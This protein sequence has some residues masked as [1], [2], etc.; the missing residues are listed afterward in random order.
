MPGGDHTDKNRNS[1]IM[2]LEIIRIY[3]ITKIKSLAILLIILPASCRRDS[4]HA[5]LNMNQQSKDF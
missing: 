4:L 3:L 5:L 2:T 1:F